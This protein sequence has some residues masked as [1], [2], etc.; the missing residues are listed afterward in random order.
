MFQWA[1]TEE[2]G[3]QMK[4]TPTF[5]RQNCWQEIF[6]RL[7]HANQFPGPASPGFKNENF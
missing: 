7:K 6:V 4:N 1:K 2:S 3:N 5:E